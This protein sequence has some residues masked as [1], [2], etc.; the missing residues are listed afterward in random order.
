MY[1]SRGLRWTSCEKSRTF[2]VRFMHVL[3]Y[4]PS[5]N[6]NINRQCKVIVIFHQSS[7]PKIQVCILEKKSFYAQSRY[8]LYIKTSFLKHSSAIRE[9][10]KSECKRKENATRAL[11]GRAHAV[12]IAYNRIA[13][14]H[15]RGKK[16]HGGPNRS[17]PWICFPILQVLATQAK[18]EMK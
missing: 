11:F 10:V 18:N 15:K 14:A 12:L 4:N 5:A 13:R 17:F 3:I 6:L 1:C 16:Q 8:A 7:Y 2:H 9:K